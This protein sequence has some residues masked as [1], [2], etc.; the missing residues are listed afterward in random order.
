[1]RTQSKRWLAACTSRIA[2][3]M[4][5][6][7]LNVSMGTM[8]R[9]V[10]FVFTVS[11]GSA[12]CHMTLRRNTAKPSSNASGGSWT[13]EPGRKFP[14]YTHNC[15]MHSH[16]FPS[17]F[18][19]QN[20][21]SRIRRGSGLAQAIFSSRASCVRAH[22]QSPAHHFVADNQSDARQRCSATGGRRLHASST[23]SDDCLRPARGY[24]HLGHRYLPLRDDATYAL[25]VC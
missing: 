19:A 10:R 6:L 13:C 7:F 21:E 25:R 15:I 22:E 9:N 24:R 3:R 12:G 14:H 20:T 18:V 1:M 8:Y 11:T 17:G 5:R 2:S 23:S 16:H 4:D